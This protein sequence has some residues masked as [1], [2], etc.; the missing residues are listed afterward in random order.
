[1]ISYFQPENKN[2]VNNEVMEGNRINSHCWS[3]GFEVPTVLPTDEWGKSA[4]S[5]VYMDRGLTGTIPTQ[6]GLV[7]K[8]TMLQLSSNQLSLAIPSELG[9][10]GVQMC[11]SNAC[12]SV[13]VTLCRI[14]L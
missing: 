3:G 13:L 6:F 1:M 11:S 10:F 8:A 14:C 9:A 12:Y 5:I 2:T 7:T 4:N